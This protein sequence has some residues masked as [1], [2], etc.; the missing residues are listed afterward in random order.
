VRL[1]GRDHYLGSWPAGQGKPP[2]AVSEAYDRL[3]AEWLAG[4]R[5][6]LRPAGGA[7]PDLS[8]NE[9]AL[10]YWKE[11]AEAYYGFEQGKGTAF[12]VRDALRILKE[13]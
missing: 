1:N 6:L 5:Q 3:I 7:P 4:G 13:L 8:V 10:A 9:L 2:P 12:N 11:Y